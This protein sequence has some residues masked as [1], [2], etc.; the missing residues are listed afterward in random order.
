MDETLHGEKE[1]EI[2]GKE[3]ISVGLQEVRQKQN[4]K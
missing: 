4:I 3:K 2:V 1:E